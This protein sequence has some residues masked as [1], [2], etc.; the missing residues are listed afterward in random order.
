MY[1]FSLTFGYILLNLVKYLDN[2]KSAIFLVVP[3]VNITSKLFDR[4]LDVNIFIVLKKLSS[5]L[6]NISPSIVS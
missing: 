4:L 3:I 6:N 1:I 5:D 2:T